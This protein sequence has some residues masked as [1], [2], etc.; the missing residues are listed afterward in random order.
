MA[1]TTIVN[2]LC[3]QLRLRLRVELI[4]VW[5]VAAS[6]EFA[7]RVDIGITS[8]HVVYPQSP[9]FWMANLHATANLLNQERN[10]PKLPGR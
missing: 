3:G 7:I 2:L 9:V 6:R 10:L 1:L 8:L 4:L 5:N